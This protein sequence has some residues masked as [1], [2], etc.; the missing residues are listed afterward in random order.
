[1]KGNVPH[2]AC[3]VWLREFQRFVLNKTTYIWIPFSRSHTPSSNGRHIALSR[4]SFLILL[5]R[6]KWRG[7]ISAVWEM[8]WA[9]EWEGSPDYRYICGRLWERA[10]SCGRC[11]VSS[12][13][14][15]CQLLPETSLPIS[16]TSPACGTPSRK[17]CSTS[18]ASSTPRAALNAANG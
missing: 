12:P 3:N 8:F 9:V 14:L 13:H 10:R 2:V 16:R 5:R 15:H 7:T 17:S 4:L 1:M 6:R 11:V 18:G